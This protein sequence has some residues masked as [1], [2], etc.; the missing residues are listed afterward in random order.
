MTEIKKFI[1]E[2]PGTS[3]LLS[4]S[5][6]L[7]IICLI[8]VFKNLFDQIQNFENFNLPSERSCIV[9]G[10]TQN[11]SGYLVPESKKGVIFSATFPY[12]DEY[13]M[14]TGQKIAPSGGIEPLG[15]PSSTYRS[16]VY[17][18]YA[19]L[20]ENDGSFYNIDQ[21]K[22]NEKSTVYRT[23]GNVGNYGVKVYIMKPSGEM[24]GT[25]RNGIKYNVIARRKLMGFGN[26]LIADQ[27]ILLMDTNGNVCKNFDI[28]SNLK[29]ATFI[30]D[31]EDA[32]YQP[33]SIHQEIKF[34]VST[35]P[36]T[37]L[38]FSPSPINELSQRTMY[39]GYAPHQ[40]KTTLQ[41]SKISV[42]LKEKQYMNSTSIIPIKKSNSV[43]PYPNSLGGNTISYQYNIN[44]T[45]SGYNYVEYYIFCTQKENGYHYIKS[46]NIVKN[47]LYP[48]DKEYVGS[49]LGVSVT[50]EKE[51]INGQILNPG[52]FFSG[53]NP[54]RNKYSIVA[55]RILYGRNKN[56]KISVD[57]LVIRDENGKGY[58]EYFDHPGSRTITFF[59]NFDQLSRKNI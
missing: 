33:K 3:L 20:L 47:W 21:R 50:Y 58:F 37:M 16:V 6:I 22:Y 52:D 15:K 14:A 4:I 35:Q 8:L 53:M 44:S 46:R 18:L 42:N 38:P 2:N 30:D 12:K 59:D 48:E 23:E 40:D 17:E 27:Y 56:D 7:F 41:F 19:G 43:S 32:N 26:N 31:F 11:P 29:V 51:M 55:Q 45:I 54:E 28:F 39:L 5:S 36:P 9:Y 13:D 25:A 57:Y 34:P 49:F 10:Y 1:K 24:M